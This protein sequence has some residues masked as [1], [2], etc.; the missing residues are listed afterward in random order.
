MTLRPRCPPSSPSLETGVTLEIKSF[1]H[2]PATTLAWFSLHQAK[3]SHQQ[4]SF[5]RSTITT[6]LVYA[7]GSGEKGQLGNGRTGEHIITSGR[8]IFDTE[9]EPRMS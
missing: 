8:A 2:L 3:V 6:Y 9:H 7:F 5:Q 4:R 1:R